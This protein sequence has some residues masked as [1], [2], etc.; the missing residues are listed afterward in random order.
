MIGVICDKHQM[1]SVTEFFEL[2]K[3]P[4]EWYVEAKQYDVVI[5][6]GEADAIPQ[7]RLIVVFGSERKS[8][9]M[10]PVT[11]L[12]PTTETVLVEYEA[13]KLPIYGKLACF[14]RYDESILAVMGTAEI[15][16]VEYSAQGQTIVRLGYDLFDEVQFLLEQGQPVDQALMPTLDVH[17]GLLRQWIVD[18]GV[19][20]VEVPPVPSGYDFV[21]CLTHDVDFIR[22]RDHP[23][24]DRSVGG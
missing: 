17:I 4:W 15:V 9:D 16:G 3:V 7:A 10:G 14:E 22:I 19:C 21:A 13:W 6:A 20:L 2:F 12:A 1:P 23:L 18:A 8:C 24:F 5:I 11:I